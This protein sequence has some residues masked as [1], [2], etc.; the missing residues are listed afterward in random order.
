MSRKSRHVRRYLDTTYGLYETPKTPYNGWRWFSLWTVLEA[1][2]NDRYLVHRLI[3]FLSRNVVHMI[4]DT[5]KLGR[6]RGHD[7]TNIAVPRSILRVRSWTFDTWLSSG[8]SR[9]AKVDTK[10]NKTFWCTFS[11]FE[12][13]GKN[14]RPAICGLKKEKKKVSTIECLGELE[15]NHVSKFQVQTPKTQRGIATFLKHHYRQENN[16]YCH[17]DLRESPSL[18][19]ICPCSALVQVCNVL[20]PVPVLVVLVLVP[21]TYLSCIYV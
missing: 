6:P 1:W 3:R 5:Y 7:F 2:Q 9:H 19:C 20:V 13:Q 12:D 18:S 15:L 8:S 11:K 10:K 16:R 21:G 14:I 4:R 17:E